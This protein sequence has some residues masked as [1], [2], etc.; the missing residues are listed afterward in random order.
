MFGFR[1]KL[2]RLERRYARLESQISTLIQSLSH[3]AQPA[4]AVYRVLGEAPVTA[5]FERRNQ[6]F[7]K[8]S[9]NSALMDL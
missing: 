7:L 8:Q 3:P 6:F 2:E 1:R 5:N 9:I 4:V